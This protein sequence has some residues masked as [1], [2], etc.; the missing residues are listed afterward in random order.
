MDGKLPL[1]GA[2]LGHMNH[3]NFGGHKLHL[4]EWLKFTWSN[5][6]CM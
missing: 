2:W 1:K 3:L 6:A 5:F 4:Q